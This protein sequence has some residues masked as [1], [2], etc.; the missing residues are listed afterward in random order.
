M[1]RAIDQPGPNQRPSFF[2]KCF[3]GG[4]LAVGFGIDGFGGDQAEEAGEAALG[5]QL[6]LIDSFKISVIMV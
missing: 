1:T 4:L 3:A 6:V 5:R 2:S